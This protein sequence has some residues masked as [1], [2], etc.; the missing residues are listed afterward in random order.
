V[1]YVSDQDGGY[2]FEDVLSKHKVAD[3]PHTEI[4]GKSDDVADSQG[5]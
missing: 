3:Y 4:D 2:L 1:I 5:S